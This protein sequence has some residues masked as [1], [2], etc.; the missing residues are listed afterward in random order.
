MKNNRFEIDEYREFI[1]KRI[2]EQIFY[3]ALTRDNITYER[4]SK[5]V[6]FALKELKNRNPTSIARMI[7]GYAHVYAGA[8]MFDES[9]SDEALRV[10]SYKIQTA[11]IEEEETT[12]VGELLDYIKKHARQL[13]LF[14]AFE[15]V[16]KDREF[17]VS[18][19]DLGSFA[20]QRRHQFSIA[21]ESLSK[22]F[23]CI[24]D[25][26]I[27]NGLKT[28]AIYKVNKDTPKQFMFHQEVYKIWKAERGK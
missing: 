25:R 7:E 27:N 17:L 15:F 16:G 2:P 22:Y 28:C 18:I 13:E 19:D 24:E 1:K 5:F 11:H 23:P 3:T 9:L 6:S 21:Y 10:L 12:G 4:Y 8:M 20:E 26:E 14:G